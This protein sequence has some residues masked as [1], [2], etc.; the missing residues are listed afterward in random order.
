VLPLVDDLRA[1]LHEVERQM[2][3]RLSPDQRNTLYRLV[4]A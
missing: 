2:H 1:R 3:V 4:Q